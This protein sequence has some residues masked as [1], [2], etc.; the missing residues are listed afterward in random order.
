VAARVARELLELDQEQRDVARP[1]GSS[2]APEAHRR[3]SSALHG[4]LLPE[5]R[6]V[7]LE[8]F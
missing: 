3:I 5:N 8:K 7:K 1:S 2:A 6:T 4:A